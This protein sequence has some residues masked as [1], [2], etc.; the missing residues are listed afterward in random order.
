MVRSP[1]DRG[2]YVRHPFMARRTVELRTRTRRWWA[3][4]AAATGITAVMGGAVLLPNSQLAK[5]TCTPGYS[6][7]SGYN[8]FGCPPITAS[9]QGYW[10]AASDGGVFTFGA[11]TFYGSA[12]ALP[13]N[14][15]V[16]GMAVTP[17]N[18]G[19]WLVASDG[20]VFRYGSAGFFGSTGGMTLNK[21]VVGI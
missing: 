18:Q 2:S 15:P 20:G 7:Y 5:V 1:T 21:P 6:G 13:L 19:Y 12:A 8:S 3:S 16:V 9:Q 17:D 10:E 14:K 4:V 11:A